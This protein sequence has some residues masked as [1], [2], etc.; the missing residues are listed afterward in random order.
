VPHTVVIL[1]AEGFTDSGP[2][3]AFDVLRT[4]NALLV[5]SGRPAVFDVRIASAKGGRI[6]AA[7]GVE[8][9]TES[10]RSAT[11]HASVLLVPGAW[12]DDGAAIDALLARTEVGLLVR[13]I[14]RLHARGVIVGSS[15]G[16]A[17]LLAE[18]GVLDGHECTTAW[19][20]AEHLQ[21]RRP[22]AKVN[23]D[24]SLVV[25][26]N[27]LTAGAVFAQADL[28][29]FLVA[30][31]VGPT[32][33][34][35]C[36]RL[37]LLDAHPSQAPYMAL[38]QVSTNDEIVRSAEQWVRRNLSK[39]FRVPAL[40]RALGVA[41]RTLSRRLLAGVG[42]GPIGFVQRLRVERA[43]QLLETTRLSLQEI[44]TQVGYGD[45]TTLRR[46]IQRE[47]SSSP[48]EVRRRVLDTRRA[49]A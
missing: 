10:V 2:S 15:C 47:T 43:L 34:R 30:K 19:W 21:K 12:A 13:A 25:R 33:A 45:A 17:F 6:R 36:S 3:I 16:G 23:Q 26:G 48:G 14:K 5:R 40:A 1:V 29:L 49:T 37:L 31:F 35:Q 24:R 4:A 44:A 39:P 7:S 46:L 42:T 28:V 8:T 32:V 9:N 22:A 27:V 41:T 20:L 38:H 18:A 11:R